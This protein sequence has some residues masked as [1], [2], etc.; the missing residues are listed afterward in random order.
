MLKIIGVALLIAVPSLPYWTPVWGGGDDGGQGLRRQDFSADPKWELH[1]SR[2]LQQQREPRRTRQAFGYSRTNHARG[3]AAGE[4]GGWIQRSVTPAWYAMPIAEKTLDHKL[5]ASGRFAVTRAEGGSG[6]LFGW[7]NETSRG[8]RTPNSL[9]FRIDGNGGK[10]W[11]FYEY[12]TRNWLTGGA[13]CFEGDAYQ[14]TKT[15]P[16]AGDGTAHDWSLA[17]DPEA[18]EELGLVTFTLDG[19]AYELPLAPGH[20]A[21]G[22]TFNRFGMFNQQSSGDGMD[23][24]FDDLVIDG[25]RVA[26]DDDPRWE[27]RG[28]AGEFVDRFVRPF[29]DFGFGD[30]NFA[31]GKRGEIGGVIWR[32]AAPSFYADRV[33]PLSLRDELYAEGKIVLSKATS[34][35]GA[36]I[37]WFD[38]KTKF[39][40]TREEDAQKNLLGVL[41][42]GPSRVGHYF[43]AAYRTSHAQGTLEDEGPVIKPDGN[44]HAWSIRYAPPGR[45]GEDGRIVV[46]FDG[47]ERVTQVRPGHVRD[48]ATFDRFGIF[49]YNRGGMFVEMYVDDLRYTAGRASK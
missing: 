8:W 30:T 29:H 35:S 48:G 27:A 9:T 25:T 34:D 37:G 23:V 26:F 49:N 43:R 1:R 42:E 28:N 44:V 18:R 45:D 47:Q 17:Y 19:K 2:L 41:V 11:V 36:Y 14:T 10:C 4:I 31:G 15:K 32:D 13:G 6:M 33:G 22:A 20:R 46:R 21:D 3:R 12:G 40:T 39:E 7:F 16:L 5:L 24:Y 38:S